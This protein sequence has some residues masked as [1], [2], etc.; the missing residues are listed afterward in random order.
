MQNNRFCF[1]VVLA[2]RDLFQVV[3]ELKKKEIELA[4]QHIQSKTIHEHQPVT[5]SV[6]TS[7]LDSS[8]PPS[9]KIS[10]EPSTSKMS[11]KEVNKVVHWKTIL[12]CFQ[13]C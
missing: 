2:M 12:S 10:H 5:L 4:R 13:S 6:K 11:H 8:S 7:I 1:K 9:H 3:F